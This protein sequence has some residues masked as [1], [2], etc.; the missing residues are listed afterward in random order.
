MLAGSSAGAI[1]AFNMAFTAQAAGFQPPRP[2][3]IFSASGGHAYAK[4]VAAEHVGQVLALHNPKDERVPIKSMRKMKRALGTQMELI[5]SEAML[6]G[7]VAA[8]PAEPRRRTYRRL[9]DF[10]WRAVG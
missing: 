9:A 8:R 7:H 10:V 2:D 4:L 1:T 6:H 5:E 3:G